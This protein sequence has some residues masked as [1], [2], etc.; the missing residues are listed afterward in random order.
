MMTV[1]SQHLGNDQSPFDC[2][3]SVAQN[4]GTAGFGMKSH[5]LSAL[6]SYDEVRPLTEVST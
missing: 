1:L 5:A 3:S 4:L 2:T 6:R